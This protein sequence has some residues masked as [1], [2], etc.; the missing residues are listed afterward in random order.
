M[1][2]IF[3]DFIASNI[4]EYLAAVGSNYSEADVLVYV[5]ENFS[6]NTYLPLFVQ[7]SELFQQ[8]LDNCTTF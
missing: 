7:T 8:N 6:T 4:I 1:D 3:I 5:D 2:L